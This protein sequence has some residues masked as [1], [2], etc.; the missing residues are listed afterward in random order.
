MLEPTTAAQ[1][2]SLG[3]HFAKIGDTLESIAQRMDD[4]G[5]PSIDV[6]AQQLFNT[7]KNNVKKAVDGLQVIAF[8][9]VSQWVTA[10]E[11]R[12][13]AEAAALPAPAK[14]VKKAVNKK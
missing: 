1:F 10:E 8:T 3:K 9:K 14:P 4:E 13:E 11:E 12:A 2:R 7:Y 6:E 5:C